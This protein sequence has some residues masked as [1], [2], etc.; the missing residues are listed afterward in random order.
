MCFVRRKRTDHGEKA[1]IKK[2]LEIIVITFVIL[3]IQTSALYIFNKYSPV[4][5]EV[6]FDKS[7]PYRVWWS[8]EYHPTEYDIFKYV[9]I[10]V[11]WKDKYTDHAK[12]LIKQVKC[13]SNDQLKTD[14]L[15]FYC[16]EKH[17]G[18]A[19][20]TDRLGV[21]VKVFSY[22]GKIPVG[23]S[24]VMGTHYRSYDSRYFGLIKKNSIIKEVTPVFKGVQS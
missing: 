17:I 18:T 14:G 6:S 13:D 12:F 16:N 7:L 19:L 24:F 11:Y 10:E 2:A 22:D 4:K 23:Q 1:M 20:K 9:E 15:E 21:P 5:L 8:K 3:I